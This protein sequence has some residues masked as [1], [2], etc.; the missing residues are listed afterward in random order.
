[1]AFNFPVKLFRALNNF[2]VI[3][4]WLPSVPKFWT[5]L[6]TQNVSLPITL[7]HWI[8]LYLL[9]SSQIQIAEIILDS[10]LATHM[11]FSTKLY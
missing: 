1:M 11:F 4:T 8:R 10:F 9:V 2:L 6:A 7:W 5:H 3:A